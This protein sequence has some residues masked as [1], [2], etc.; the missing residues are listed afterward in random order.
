M[1]YDDASRRAEYHGKPVVLTTV[2]GVTEGLTMVFELADDGKTLK[3]LHAV[4][5]VFAKRADGHEFSGAELEYLMDDDLY[6]LKGRSGD[7]ARVKQPAADPKAAGARC[8]FTSGQRLEFS[9][10]TGGFRNSG[11]PFSTDQ[12]ACT[13]TLRKPR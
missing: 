6:I 13:E 5:G 11:S 10:R 8:D 7:P 12:L 4:G 3:R 1:A 2:D 9:R